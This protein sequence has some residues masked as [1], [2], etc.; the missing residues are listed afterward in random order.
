M[1]IKYRFAKAKFRVELEGMV[2]KI[3]A[4]SINNDL[5]STI[6]FA[7]TCLNIA[8]VEIPDY[9][10][11]QPFLKDSAP[12][13][14]YI[15]AARDRVDDA[16]D[17][18]RC[19]RSKRFKYIRN[20]M[21]NTPWNKPETYMLK[22]HPTLAAMMKLFEE[23]KLNQNQAK[24]LAPVKPKEEL[25]GVVEDPFEFNNLVS[26]PGFQDILVNLRAELS[27]WLERMNDKGA[28]PEDPETLK[29]AKETFKK[30]KADMISDRHLSKDDMVHSLYQYWQRTLEPTRKN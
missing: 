30:M 1:S 11:G 16:V 23:G 7:P 6:D 14:D 19:V 29:A 12:E 17:R 3:K 2:E 22:E 13:Q 15:F 25:Y 26:D 24:W 4:G 8:G 20:F 10:H 28:E 9:M 18:I 21:A 5:I 27:Q